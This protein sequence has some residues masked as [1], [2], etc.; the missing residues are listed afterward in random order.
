MINEEISGGFDEQGNP[1]NPKGDK[2][3]LLR[4]NSL[5]GQKILIVMLWSCALSE[6]ENKLLDPKKY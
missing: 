6:V 3:G 2:I 1:I 5:Q 4:E